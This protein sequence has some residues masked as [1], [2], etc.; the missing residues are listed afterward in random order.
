MRYDTLVIQMDLAGIGTVLF[1]SA[2]RRH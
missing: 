2:P 1:R